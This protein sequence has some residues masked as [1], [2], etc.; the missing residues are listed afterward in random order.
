MV[1]CKIM[2][3]SLLLA[4]LRVA[5]AAP[6]PL[7]GMPKQQRNATAEPVALV[8]AGAGRS[9]CGVGTALMEMLVGREWHK[10]PGSAQPEPLCHSEQ[11]PCLCS[12]NATPQEYCTRTWE[13]GGHHMVPSLP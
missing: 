2:I 4:L 5:V 6:Q 8:S 10:W 11:L 3:Q 13:E 1:I 12:G 7:L 9:R